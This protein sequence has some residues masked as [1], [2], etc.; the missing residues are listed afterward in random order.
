[1]KDVVNP[2]K[3]PSGTKL[4]CKTKYCKTTR[5]ETWQ[6][7]QVKGKP[8][9]PTRRDLP[10]C[11]AWTTF[12]EVMSGNGPPDAD[13]SHAPGTEHKQILCCLTNTKGMRDLKGRAAHEVGQQLTAL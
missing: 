10:K 13:G 12:D 6:G 3:P 8:K 5:Q 9:K 1:M 2:K 4:K 7:E 11:I